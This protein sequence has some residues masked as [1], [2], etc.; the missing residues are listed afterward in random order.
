[1]LKDAPMTSAAGEMS[2]L[3]ISSS[4]GGSVAAKLT[5]LPAMTPKV[6]SYWV[7]TLSGARGGSKRVGNPVA[8]S[9]HGPATAPTLPVLPGGKYLTN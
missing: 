6:K 9:T 3:T 4:L 7:K 2:T 8:I 1:M 5:C